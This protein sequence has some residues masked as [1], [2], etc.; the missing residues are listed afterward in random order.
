MS[1]SLSSL[2]FTPHALLSQLVTS[3]TE[4]WLLKLHTKFEKQRQS[5]LSLRE[6]R[7]RLDFQAST[8][9]IRESDWQVAP[10]PPD[11]EKR[12]VEITGPADAKMI[13]NALNSGA[14]AFM[15]DLEDA[16]SPT[17]DNVLQGHLALQQVK[18]RE[19]VY[20]EAKTGRRLELHK[21][22][23]TTLLVRPRGWHLPEPRV[24]VEATPGG[25][26]ST[27]LSASLFD[28]GLHV[29]LSESLPGGLYFYLPKL[30]SA[31]EARLWA[32]LF[33]S[34]E[35]HFQIPRG[36]IRC[37][38]LIETLPAAFQMH[39]ILWELRHWIVGLNAGRWDYLFSA[40]KSTE[41][42]GLA[43]LFPDRAALSMQTPFMQAYAEEI[44]RIAHR[45]G[46]HAMGGMSA[47]IPSRRE[48]E[49][50]ARALE[51]VRR[52]KE[53]EA[54][55]G[56][57]GTWVAH[58]DLIA[59]AREAFAA[60]LGD[61]VSQKHVG[62]DR[63]AATRQELLPSPSTLPVGSQL[64]HQGLLANIDV[65]LRYLSA[66]LG[67]LGAV[68][69]YNLM[70]DAATAEI[71]RAQLWQAAHARDSHFQLSAILAD[72]DSVAQALVADANASSMSPQAAAHLATARELLK[73]LTSSSKFISFLTLPALE[74][75]ERESSRDRLD[76]NRERRAQH[77]SPTTKGD[78]L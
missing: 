73:Q 67:G 22:S 51:Q 77:H 33:Q 52:D 4:A 42:E 40:I 3:E 38:V 63:S 72:I 60:R 5:L 75:L 6:T 78:P 49:V 61:R 53:R 76:V 71:S 45:R 24:S 55:Q 46:A 66:W 18:A 19:L 15:A 12:W 37:T 69:I 8:L 27:S 16:L 1:A 17:W 68:A 48:P 32:E 59:T 9:S 13:L 39:E 47:F 31:G 2:K 10:P 65:S 26:E 50:N 14:D 74:A 57:D 64:T 29:S 70:E 44:V 34:A 36:R 21:D 23:R 54:S 35:D 41:H 11:L 28:F 62:H 56:F 43:P 25:F 30:E 58:P 7:G 20:E